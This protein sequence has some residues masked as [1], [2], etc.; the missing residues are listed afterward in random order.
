ML[1]TNDK[2][3]KI[4]E[5]LLRIKAVKLQPNDPFTWA[6]GWNSPIYCDNRISLSYP[7]V[8]TYIKTAF[9]DLIKENF[10]MP[11]VIAGVATGGLPQG[12][13]VAQELN[14]P[15]IYVRSAAKA[16]GM[17]NMIEGHYSKNQKVVLIEDL[18]S[19][20]GSSIK[21]VKALKNQGLDVLGLAAIFTYGF[22]IASNNFNE[23]NCKAPTLSDYS[24]LIDVAMKNNY[25]TNSD[26]DSLQNWR[27]NPSNWNK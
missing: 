1:K 27:I 12:A 14:L 23:I 17:G 4:A 20:G 8:R 6:S 25:I 19:T 16:H 2:A 9:C 26:L 5:Y 15:F 11:D 18:I 13:L 21:G 22:E 24:T 3:I 7:E 10:G